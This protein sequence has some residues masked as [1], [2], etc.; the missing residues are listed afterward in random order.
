MWAA[1]TM[2]IALPARSPGHRVRLLVQ[3]RCG[4]RRDPRSARAA[5]TGFDAFALP[6]AMAAMPLATLLGATR[7][8]VPVYASSGFTSSG[9]TGWPPSSPATPPPDTTA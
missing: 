9:P 4:G 2:V 6:A 5:I 3:R 1:T 8:S 7:T